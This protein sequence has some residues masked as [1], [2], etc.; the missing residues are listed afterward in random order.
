MPRI[1]VFDTKEKVAQVNNAISNEIAD[2]SSKDT[3]WA[4]WD[5]TYSFVQGMN[6]DYVKNNLMDA[7]FSNLRLNLMVVVNSTGQVV[8]CE[9]FDLGGNV[10]IP[11]DPGLLQ[12]ILANS[13]LWNFSD[14]NSDIRGVLAVSNQSMIFVSEPILTSLGEGPIM[15]AL[16][17]GRNMGSEEIDRLSQTVGLPIT[18]YRY[19][20]PQLPNDFKTA[21]SSLTNNDTVFVQPLSQDYVAGYSLTNDVSSNPGFI[22]RIELPRDFYTQGLA[23]TNFF[24]VLALSLCIVFGM[25]MMLLLE[26]GILNPIQRLTAAVRE[27]ATTSSDSHPTIILEKTK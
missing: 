14:A 16:I 7:T 8:Y 24:I 17:M 9:A 27:M 10:E 12:E 22:I 26:K 15:G 6:V 11:V 23:T 20:D 13:F 18:V 21:K 2:L 5:D 19:G 3:D 1:E 25:A 4:A